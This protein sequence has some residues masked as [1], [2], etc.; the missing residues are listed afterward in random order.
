MKAV[1]LTVD[2]AFMVSMIWAASVSTKDCENCVDC[3]DNKCRRCADGYALSRIYSRR[4][5]VSTCPGN[6]VQVWD[7]VLRT[8]A[9]DLIQD[10]GTPSSNC[11]ECLASGSCKNCIDGFA[12]RLMSENIFGFS[13]VCDGACTSCVEPVSGLQVCNTSQASCSGSGTTKQPPNSTGPFSSTP[14]PQTVE[15]ED[16]TDYYLDDDY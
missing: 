16:A 15:A 5:C 6:G 11:Q 1:L 10:C 2:L 7:P 13:N 14:T 3:A 12:L 9:C 4:F 8:D